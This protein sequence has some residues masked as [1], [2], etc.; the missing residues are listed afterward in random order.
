MKIKDIPWYNRPGTRLK[1]KGVSVLSDS[2]LLSILLGRGNTKE[3][4]LDL[5]NRILKTYNLD[6]LSTLTYHEL[7]SELRSDKKADKKT[8]QTAD[9][10]PDINAE[11]KPDYR[12]DKKADQKS[13]LNTHL[14]SNQKPDPK[15]HLKSD[16]TNDIHAMR[17]LAMFE[18]FNRTNKLNS[19]GFKQKITCAEDVFN[20]FKDE[21]SQKKKEHFYAL[22]LDSKNRIIDEHLISI[23]TLNASLIHPREIFSPAIKAAANSIILVHNHP[24]G[25]VEASKADLEVTNMLFSAGDLMG[26]NLLDHIIIGNNDYLSMKEK[27]IIK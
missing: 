17:I 22:L 24:S 6:K 12:S 25:V 10:R 26:I 20:H 14:K 21:L 8:N 5:S 11:I 23:G 9:I 19:K 15:T 4:A 7:L 27:R 16:I 3:N 13:D 2:E 18:L 1:Q